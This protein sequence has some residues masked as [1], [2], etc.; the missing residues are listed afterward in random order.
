MASA[1][2]RRTKAWAPKFG[3]EKLV[4]AKKTPTPPRTKDIAHNANRSR[5]IAGI[6]KDPRR[7]ETSILIDR[8]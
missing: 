5:R 8:K 2:H 1:A 4:I 6:G 7:I 3:I